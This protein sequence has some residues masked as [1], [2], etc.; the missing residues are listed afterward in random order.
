MNRHKQRKQ[1]FLQDPEVAEGYLEM[2]AEFQPL[3]LF[4]QANSHSFEESVRPV[5]VAQELDLSVV[6]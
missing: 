3:T 5:Y 1:K 4:E 6:Q 2:A